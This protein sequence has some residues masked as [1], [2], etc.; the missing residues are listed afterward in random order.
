MLTNTPQGWRMIM[1]L[2]TLGYPDHIGNQ[3]FIAS[4]PRDSS[5]GVIAQSVKLWLRDCKY[6]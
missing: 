5:D 6:N 3:N 4:P 2:T 1:L